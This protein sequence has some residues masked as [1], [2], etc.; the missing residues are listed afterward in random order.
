MRLSPYTVIVFLWAML[1][2]KT[3]AEYRTTRVSNGGTVRGSVVL[4]G[5]VPR[6][7]GLKVAKDEAWC[8]TVKPSAR[9]SVGKNKGVGNA[10][11]YLEGITQGKRF[12]KAS[13]AVLDQNGCDYVPHVMVIPPGTT[14]EIVNSDPV[15]H[16]VHTYNGHTTMRTVFNIAQPIRGQRT[17]IQGST[18]PGPGVYLATCDAGHP[19]MSAYVWVSDHPYYTVTHHD[20]AFELADVPPGTYTLKM[21]HE[22]VRIVKQDEVKGQVTRYYYEDPYELAQQ[23]TVQPNGTVTTTFDLVLR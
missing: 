8:G 6:G 19:W 3:A 21:W 10:V 15:L 13:T 18:F 11:I 17:Q 16:N 2:S 12:P 14:L 7:T 4:R 1:F 23:I 5:D 22:G 20:G 9:L